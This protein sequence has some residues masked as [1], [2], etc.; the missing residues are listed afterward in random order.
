M[1]LAPSM[2][3][4]INAIPPKIFG[5][6]TYFGSSWAQDLWIVLNGCENVNVNVE[7]FIT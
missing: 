3:Q 7:Y 1:P 6:M 2:R 4:E 5:G